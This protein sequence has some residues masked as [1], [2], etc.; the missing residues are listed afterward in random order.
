MFYWWI[1]RDKR[2]ADA[3]RF[4]KVHRI[5]DNSN[6]HGDECLRLTTAVSGQLFFHR[7]NCDRIFVD[8]NESSGNYN[9]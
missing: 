5:A 3:K 8:M 4:S 9:T 6:R 7:A 2:H 1:A